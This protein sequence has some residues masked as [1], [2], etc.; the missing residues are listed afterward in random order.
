MRYEL[1]PGR[2]PGADLRRVG[3]ALIT[4]A[5]EQVEEE[6]LSP[7]EA[8]HEA[9]KT[10][11]KLRGLLRLVRPAAPALYKA[12]NRAFRDA[13]RH[14]AVVRDADVALET[15]DKVLARA[16][17]PSASSPWK[18]PLGAVRPE[19]LERLRARLGD[20]RDEAHA[21]AGD[22]RSRLDELRARMLD[23]RERVA[24]WQLPEP[25]NPGDDFALLGHGL[26]KTYKR[27]RKA[28]ERAYAEPGAARFHE[29]RKRTKYL[30]Y[31]LRLLRPAWPKLLKV[32][33]RA[34]KDLQRLLGDDHDLAVLDEL[35]ETLR[36]G[37][38][39][40]PQET[41]AVH[42]LR[43]E[44]ARQS[45]GLRQRAQGLGALV[46]AERPEAL[47]RRIDTYWRQATRAAAATTREI[48]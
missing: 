22:A 40:T 35:L 17:D 28:M 36:M 27:G 48:P 37:E 19:A 15:F 33:R 16:G 47:H 5:V 34:V 3:A 18:S 13:A 38:E 21:G 43:A 2:P 7:D 10:M 6:A 24:D 25:D 29:W 44:M 31:H 26:E 1:S 4:Q 9:R 46:Y 8:V 45:A 30:G 11:K 12:E 39:P 32:H 41:E 23:A 14:L 20:Y 42:A